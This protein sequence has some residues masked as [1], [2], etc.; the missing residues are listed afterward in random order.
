M[1]LLKI[2]CFGGLKIYKDD[3][4]ITTLLKKTQAFLAYL[5]VERKASL[6]RDKLCAMFWPESGEM[7]AKYNLRYTLWVLR[8]G[9]GFPEGPNYEFVLSF[10]D[11]CQFN[12]EAN[13]WLDTEEF[14]KKIIL[15]KNLE[16]DD[17]ARIEYL[18]EAVNL[19]RGDFL[20]GFFIK[21]SW[22]FENW[23]RIQRERFFLEYTRTVANLA[24]LLIDRKE[25]QKVVTL[26]NKS[27]LISP[28]QEEFHQG[29]IRLYLLMGERT[30][31]LEQYER[32]REVLKREMRMTPAAETQELRRSIFQAVP[33]KEE[34]EEE[35][36]IPL[37]E[38]ERDEEKKEIKSLN[39]AVTSTS[40]DLDEIL[41]DVPDGLTLKYKKPVSPPF[42]NREK[43]LVELSQVLN[44]VANAGAAEVV[45]IKG[46]LGIGKT[47]LI[48][49]FVAQRS[50]DAE[51]VYCAT[52]HLAN[53]IPSHIFYEGAAI[54]L[55]QKLSQESSQLDKIKHLFFN[56]H[57]SVKIDKTA[58]THSVEPIFN[59]FSAICVEKP[60]ILI[61]E[62]LHWLSPS[63][64]DI[65]YELISKSLLKRIIFIATYRPEDEEN[66]ALTTLIGRLQRI[67]KV[68]KIPL[69]R[70]SYEDV[71][72]LLQKS[73]ET[74]PNIAQYAETI[75]FFTEGIPFLITL[76][77]E[78]FLSPQFKGTLYLPDALKDIVAER[79]KRLS[80]QAFYLL[81]I[82]AVLGNSQKQRDLLTASKMVADDFLAYLLELV[83]KGFIN[84]KET[85]GEITYT[86]THRLLPAVI[87][88]QMSLTE[89]N[90]IKERCSEV[91]MESKDKSQ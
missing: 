7:Q 69:N 16:I 31:A 65:F 29:L 2:Y 39:L 82:A 53:S 79:V 76:I 30:K 23:Q 73:A 28:V 51:V 10:R 4:P 37:V 48:E 43:E 57:S 36:E 32:C 3:Q 22:E 41:K 12:T 60:L 78:E 54:W 61:T 89:K 85:A 56:L 47:R 40:F 13:Y 5:T 72:R 27:L 74:I 67:V 49:E 46:E 14:E 63:S 75:Y 33:E 45:F 8:T 83:E 24:D 25:Y 19:Y 91:I 81:K 20:D 86:F 6:P 34:Q 44:E 70:L 26:Y 15:A 9:L 77:M 55:K 11:E 52:P 1:P 62:D 18:T 71:S 17:S 50:E 21:K 42:V 68:K 58:K 66:K 80:A 38:T 59:F 35:V 87:L 64:L 90:L 84:E 88:E